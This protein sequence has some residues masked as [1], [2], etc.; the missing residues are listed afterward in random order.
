MLFGVWV[1]SPW[2]EDL[3][4]ALGPVM[5]WVI[6]IVLAYIPGLVIGLMIATLL[7]SP[8][9]ELALEPPGVE[10]PG[11]TVVI[12]ASASSRSATRE[13]SSATSCC[14]RR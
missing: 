2:R 5:A 10:W 13:D 8:Y 9:R 7:L 1:S 6:P 12:A 11:V 3:E 14:T 4:R